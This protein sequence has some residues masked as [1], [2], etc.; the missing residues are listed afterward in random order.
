MVW[1]VV[2]W[3]LLFILG[4]ILAAPTKG[5]CQYTGLSAFAAMH[6]R[7][8]C[9]RYLSIVN[10]SPA[11][12]MSVLW[13]TFG[14]DPSCVER[15]LASNSHRPHL[16][17]IHFSNENCRKHGICREGEILAGVSPRGYDH[18]LITYD[19]F[20]YLA[21]Q[22]RVID[23]F[24]FTELR[25]NPHTTL[26]LSTGL[27]DQYSQVAYLRLS[28]YLHAPGHWPHIINRNPL[29]GRRNIHG[30]FLERHG[31]S[32]RCLKGINIVNEDGSDQSTS[33][34]RK[35][36]SRTRNCF[37]RFLWRKTHQGRSKAS[38]RINTPPRNRNF[39]ISERDVR[40]LGK[41]LAEAGV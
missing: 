1:G 16:L 26:V 2:V 40:E 14:T 3:R 32:A 5:H 7:F 36:L 21:I 38:G 34:S 33:E 17:Q 10:R 31:E 12:A 20:T 41:L 25:R 30:D 29:G 27:E 35:F 24:V 9:D 11:P 23:I 6:P 22:Q 18:L 4:L 37:A 13:G 39:E 8:P 15:F 19:F 28:A